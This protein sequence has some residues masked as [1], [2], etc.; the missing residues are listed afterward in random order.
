MAW[1]ACF[2]L[3]GG[4]E[5]DSLYRFMLFKTT[6]LVILLSTFQSYTKKNLTYSQFTLPPVITVSPLVNNNCNIHSVNIQNAI[7]CF[8]KKRFN[9][10]Q[11]ILYQTKQN[12]IQAKNSHLLFTSHLYL[13]LIAIE[14]GNMPSAKKSIQHIFFLQPNFKFDQYAK[15]KKKYL[16]LFRSIKKQG[17]RLNEIEVSDITKKKFIRVTSCNNNSHCKNNVWL[18]SLAYRPESSLNSDLDCSLRGDCDS[19][20]DDNIDCSIIGD[21]DTDLD[22][23]LDGTC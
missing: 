4:E 8:E 11:A 6:L 12:A 3:K 9:Q 21:C 23:S 14:K 16:D 15:N 18:D 7:H 10:A 22:C 20:I 17:R 19:I 2:F 13:A 1:S 5:F